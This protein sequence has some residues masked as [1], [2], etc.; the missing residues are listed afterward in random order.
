MPSGENIFLLMRELYSDLRTSEKGV[1]DYIIQNPEKVVYMTID[2]LA[3]ETFTSTATILRMVKTLGIKDYRTFKI[4]LAQAISSLEFV[5]NEKM[6]SNDP[7]SIIDT[8]SDKNA[9]TIHESK[10]LID[11]KILI[12]AIDAIYKAGRVDFYGLGVSNLIAMDAQQKFI[13]LKHLCGAYHDTSAQRTACA[14]LQ[15]GDV[16]IFFS[17]SGETDIILDL[18][19]L[20][21]QIGVT[22]IAI[23]SFRKDNQIAK[24]ANLVIYFSSYA[25]V[26]IP[27]AYT[28]TRI[29]MLNVIDILYTFYIQKYG[30]IED[31]QKLN[32]IAN[33]T[34][35]K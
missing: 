13:K 15:K 22:T 2:N 20:A 32:I 12:K 14:T 17:H 18:T 16:A 33:S 4:T 6:E 5:E 27:L 8:V 11:E 34:P 30:N 25:G 24:T 9:R 3:Y 1:A 19:K 7:H 29:A 23:T 31:V 28:N 35:Q 21:N 26:D 10:S